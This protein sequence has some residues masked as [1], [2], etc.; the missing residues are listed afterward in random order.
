MFLPFRAACTGHLFCSLS[1]PLLL[2]NGFSIICLTR[3]AYPAVA[4][5]YSTDFPFLLTAYVIAVLPSLFLSRKTASMNSSVMALTIDEEGQILADEINNLTMPMACCYTKD[6]ILLGTYLNASYSCVQ[7]WIH[8]ARIPISLFPIPSVNKL[9][10]PFTKSVSV[11]PSFFLQ[12]LPSAFFLS[13]QN[14]L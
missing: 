4:A 3:S 5:R 12:E 2:T 13:S 10:F 6:C 11:S 1:S 7:L 14:H 8:E 9:E